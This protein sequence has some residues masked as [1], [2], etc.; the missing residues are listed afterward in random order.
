[1]TTRRAPAA[2]L[3]AAFITLAGCASASAQRTAP[4]PP[5]DFDAYVGR[6]LE[7]FDVP[8]AAVAI[9]KD[10]RVVLARGYGV[11]ELGRP[12]RVDAHT[13]FG[14]ASNSKAFT[15]TALGMLVEEGKLEWDAPVVDYLPW[16]RLSDPYVT[17]HLTV[18]DLLVHR[19]GLS[20][21]AGDLLWW[22]PSTYSRE[23]SVRRLAHVPL[24]TPFRANYAYDNVLYLVA[25][26][27]I[28]EVSGM[29]WEQFVESRILRP[30]GMSDSEPSYAEAAERGS[31]ATTH[32][33]VGGVVRVVQP[34]PSENANPAAGIMSSATDM[35]KWMIAQLD[36]GRAG[37]ERLWSANTQRQLWTIVTPIPSGV[38]APQVAPLRSAF[39]GYGLGFFLRDYRGHQM[40][41][42]TGGLP[43]Y[44]SR[45]AMIPELKLGVAVLTNQESGPAFDAVAFHVLDWFIQPDAP[46]DWLAAMRWSA[47]R[48][49]AST[50]SEDSAIAAA[51]T[52]NTTPSLPLEEYAG[53]YRDPWYGDVVVERGADGQLDIRMLPTAVMV[54]DLEHWHHDTFLARW[55]DRELRA[56]AFVTF[57]IGPTGDIDELRMEAASPSVDFSYDFQDL[58]L[59]PAE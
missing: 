9:V 40:A 54:G 14:I 13:T 30:L 35:A 5:R 28:E 20:L 58:V 31:P 45:V 33:R 24:A 39:N 26:G 6:V 15:A 23:E 1:M 48:S 11:R 21:G 27:L 47:E 49:A 3:A 59:E 4:T 10:G 43:G 38:P 42:H 8:G 32:A 53:A 57:V 37:D 46:H 36:S 18:R 51:R 55:H 56:D 2:F 44:L 41:T 12:E 22:P 17:A 50:A 25:G 7:T 19:S 34:F 52:P 16:F 29:T